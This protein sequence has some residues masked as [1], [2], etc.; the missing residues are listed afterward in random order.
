MQVAKD[1]SQVENM[2]TSNLQHQEA[3]E[4]ST[5]TSLISDASPSTKEA[6]MPEPM[7]LREQLGISIDNTPTPDYP[8]NEQGKVAD[9]FNIKSADDAYVL[10]KKGLIDEDGAYIARAGYNLRNKGL[11]NISPEDANVLA[12]IGAMTDID[13][14]R[15]RMYHTNKLKYYLWETGYN[16]LGGALDAAENTKDL[17][18]DSVR[19]I[20]RLPERAQIWADDVWSGKN[21]GEMIEH[22]KSLYPNDP[23]EQDII[24]FSKILPKDKD[25]FGESIRTLAQF[26]IPYVGVTKAGAFAN[27][28]KNPA[29]LG[30]ARGA[31]VD[32]TAFDGK[33]T[34]LSDLAKDSPIDN[35]L[36][37]ALRAKEGDSATMLR[38]K[39]TLE[40][41]GLGAFVEGAF[42]GI[43]LIK[44]DIAI[45][46]NGSAGYYENKIEEVA[47]EKGLKIPKEEVKETINK[48]RTKELQ[49]ALDTS[50][51]NKLMGKESEPMQAKEAPKSI[52]EKLVTKD[53]VVA[54]VDEL[55]SSLNKTKVSHKE[56]EEISNTYDV[57][58]D[59]VRN[60]YKGV[61]NVNAKVVAIGRTLND[62]GKDLYD[63]IKAYTAKGA[64]DLAEAT[65]LYTKMLQHGRMQDMF[66]GISSEIGRG[67]NAHKMLDKPFKIKDLPAEELEMNVT[68]LGGL[69]GINKALNSYAIA[70]ER[71]IKEGANLTKK[72]SRG[73]D[74]LDVVFGARQGGMLSSPATHLKNILGN[75]TM[76]GL[77]E[78]EHLL[79]LSGRTII[80]RDLKHFK[81]YY[82]KW[83]GYVAGFK[84]S[85]KLAKYSKDGKNGNAIKAFLTNKPQLDIGEKWNE[86]LTANVK[87][88]FGKMFDEDGKLIPK[89]M[90]EQANAKD[91]VADLTYN[92]IFRALTG[93]DEVFKNIAYKGELYRQAIETMNEKGLKFGSKLEQAEYFSNVINNPTTKQHSRAI[94]VAR[95]TTFT[96]PVSKANPFDALTQPIYHNLAKGSIGINQPLIWLQEMANSPNILMKMAARLAVPFRTTPGNIT[97]ELLRR[98][99]PFNA[100]SRE[101]LSDFAAGGTRKAQ[102]ISQVV[103]SASLIGAIWELYRN[104][105][106]ITTTD[107]KVRN[108]LSLANI[109][110]NSIII[111]D[112]A[113]SFDG[114]DPVSSLV[115]LVANTLSAWDK[116]ES[117]PEQDESYFIATIGA[118][119][120]TLTDKTY[121]KGV[122]DFMNL[123]SDPN[124][125]KGERM[126][127][128]AYNMI[129]SFVPMS[130]ANKVIREHW[131]DDSK[132]EKQEFLDYIMANTPFG[133]MPV[134]LDLFGEPRAKSEKL[135]FGVTNTAVFDRNSL[136]YEL[137]S[138]GVDVEPLK[139]NTISFNGVNL[140]I[141]AVDKT[142]IRGIVKELGLKEALTNLLNNPS[143]QELMLDSDKA[144]FI[145]E[146]I[147]N[148]Y[149]NAKQIYVTKEE[150]RIDKVKAKIQKDIETRFDPAL[151]NEANRQRPLWMLRRDK[152]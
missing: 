41:A 127:K 94:D 120:K 57:D 62:F 58:M 52:S 3:K 15:Y 99:P 43:S 113:Y 123:F 48:E 83:A 105:L 101:W 56:V 93:V 18:Y 87:G 9:P 21:L 126:T 36:F 50:R 46:A 25:T 91:Y 152:Q 60:A 96:T 26:L 128:Y 124:N 108:A 148:F 72:A 116:V 24:D 119:T 89:A 134:A 53:D 142:I 28:I 76:V 63:G 20:S 138:L 130:S 19:G 45:K 39:H 61:L 78:T 109:P 107:S 122:K 95:R 104:G 86:A 16:T 125:D 100:F 55:E 145:Q 133:K 6:T 22:Q 7:V 118:V 5:K 49:E 147:S 11:V 34:K 146:I 139:G 143:Y 140:P 110:E 131:L 121:L 51:A 137:A 13:D 82:Y 44:R 85:L 23:N 114:L 8:L 135:F 47:R 67:L 2:M 129:G 151:A 103:V 132:T 12:N 14:M 10:Y 33:D 40:N 144:A 111:G 37:D 71:S 4:S 81:E 80:D 29:L 1:Q 27:T 64:T 79:A 90:R 150:E 115:A 112:K 17:V 149:T 74:W 38:F 102:A 70:Y 69:S 141:E 75:L 31:S 65:E 92:F 97:K 68:N 117:D 66:K 77:R 136:E 32:F 106:I 42:K 30:M 98:M 84:D 88:L 35:A 54:H 73:G 59:F